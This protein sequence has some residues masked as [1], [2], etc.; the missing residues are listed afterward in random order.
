VLGEV[1]VSKGHC[2]EEDVQK[3]LDAQKAGDKR[4]IGQI[5]LANGAV[6]KEQLEEAL[7]EPA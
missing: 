1:L 4:L 5:L 6:T 2:T 3:A 7:G